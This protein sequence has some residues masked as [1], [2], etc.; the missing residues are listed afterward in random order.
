MP[1]SF[2]NCTSFDRPCVGE[3]ASS[4]RRDFRFFRT[5]RSAAEDRGSLSIEGMATAAPENFGS[6]RREVRRGLL[7]RWAQID[8]R[9][10]KDGRHVI[11]HDETVDRTTNGTG[12]VA[13]LTLDE[14]KKLDA[15]ASV[16]RQTIRRETA[17]VVARS[18]CSRQGQDQLV[19]GLQTGRSEAT[20]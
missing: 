19:P 8:V 16:V 6:G 1:G 11:I 15:E 4:P 17:P 20:G 12:R 14:L 2:R 18:P 9:L 13:D 7:Q 3:N 10:T 5:S